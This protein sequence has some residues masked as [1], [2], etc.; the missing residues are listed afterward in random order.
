MRCF[1][2]WGRVTCLQLE[3]RRT[4][5]VD[6]VC[7]QCLA[8][9]VLDGDFEQ[10]CDEVIFL[11][12]IRCPICLTKFEQGLWLPDYPAKKWVWRA[13]LC[14]LQGNCD[15]MDCYREEIHKYTPKRQAE[16]KGRK[17]KKASWVHWNE[18][19]EYLTG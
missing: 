4:I 16:K 8:S 19:R 5:I 10:D 6:V 17:R 13:R 15:W 18:N 11:P 9:F 7:P 2:E 12:V 14:E 3:S 1:I